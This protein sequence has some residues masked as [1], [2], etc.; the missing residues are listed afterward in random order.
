MQMSAPWFF[1]QRVLYY[2][3]KVYQQQLVES[4]NYYELRPTISISFLDSV[5]FH[6]VPALHHH[7]MV[8]DPQTQ[9]RLTEDL[10]IHIVELPKFVAGPGQLSTPFDVWCYFLRHGETLDSNCLPAPLNTPII[11]RAL[12]VLN[13]M[14]QSDHDRELYEARLKARRDNASSLAEADERGILKG[15]ILLAQKLLKQEPTSQDVLNAMPP[16][17][18]ARL[19]RQLEELLQAR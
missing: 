17:E 13:V 15:Q 6:Q 5:L 19:A 10:D 16:D 9:L 3:A 7:F 18:L 1:P 14:T 4:S 2:W 8:V 12:E 11:H